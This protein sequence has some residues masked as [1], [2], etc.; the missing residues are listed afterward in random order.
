MMERLGASALTSWPAAAGAASS[1]AVEV[2]GSLTVVAVW[3]KGAASST[4]AAV[5]LWCRLP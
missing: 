2:E 3:L 4:A 1:K 5:V